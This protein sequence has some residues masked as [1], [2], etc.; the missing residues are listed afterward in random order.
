MNVTH[1]QTMQ[2]RTRTHCCLR[3]YGVFLVLDG[4]FVG[5]VY[6][7][8]FNGEF[9]SIL[10]TLCHSSGWV[11]IVQGVRICS[12]DDDDSGWVLCE[13]DFLNIFF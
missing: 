8:S 2:A 5:L 6:C 4:K 9:I 10:A 7:V 11:H 13:S 12:S 1:S 3:M